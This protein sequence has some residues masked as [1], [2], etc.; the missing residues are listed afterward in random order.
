MR[1]TLYYV[2]C[3][4]SCTSG[5]VLF[6]WYQS[7]LMLVLKDLASSRLQNW[8]LR[9]SKISASTCSVLQTYTLSH[10]SF[11]I[12]KQDIEVIRSPQKANRMASSE[13]GKIFLL[14]Q[15]QGKACRQYFET[16]SV[17]KTLQHVVLRLWL[18]PSHIWNHHESHWREGT[19]VFMHLELLCSVFI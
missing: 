12:D 9:S 2:T 13:F 11:F 6:P 1:E 14:L 15:L 19:W 16:C 10:P 4:A 8:R 17:K 18:Y 3:I 7:V 5:W